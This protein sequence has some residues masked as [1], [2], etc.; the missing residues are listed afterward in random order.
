M[1]FCALYLICGA[2]QCNSGRSA[3]KCWI[4]LPRLCSVAQW[5]FIFILVIHEGISM[6]CVSIKGFIFA[7]GKDHYMPKL[8][9]LGCEGQCFKPARVSTVECV[10]WGFQQSR[11]TQCGITV[12]L[13][14][15]SNQVTS[16][17]CGKSHVKIS[18]KKLVH[19]HR[20]RWH[21][22]PVPERGLQK[23]NK[24]VGFFDVAACLSGRARTKWW[25]AC[26]L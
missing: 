15:A 2:N 12:S 20:V 19:F 18:V 13:S 11:G 25:Q 16:D 1:L 23:G 9:F 21:D 14:K 17:V 5:W 7:R 24:G 8:W 10:P 3:Q 22:V 26:Q 4:A 6:S